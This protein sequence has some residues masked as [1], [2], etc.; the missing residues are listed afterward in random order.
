M[1]GDS[2]GARAGGATPDLT[3]EQERR[4]RMRA[5][6]M[7][8]YVQQ[9]PGANEGEAAIAWDRA[10]R[11]RYEIESG[12]RITFERPK[13]KTPTGATVVPLHPAP[14]IPFEGS[15]PDPVEA[16]PGGGGRRWPQT[17][18]DAWKRTV[19]EGRCRPGTAQWDAAVADG[20]IT[21]DVAAL[22][23]Q[24]PPART[25]GRT[26]PLKPL[27][28]DSIPHASL[29][30]LPESEPLIAGTLDQGSVALLYGA[31]QSY[32]TF[33]ALDWAASVAAGTE[34]QGRQCE[35]MNVLYVAAEGVRGIKS[36]LAAWKSSRAVSVDKE[37]EIIR[38]PVNIYDE[39]HVQQFC[40]FVKRRGF[41][42]IAIDTLARCSGGADENS[43]QDMNAIVESAYEILGSTIDG[44][45]CVL[46]V[47]HTG[48]NGGPPRGSSAL[49]NG[50]DTAYAS[51]RDGGGMI[52]VE[53][54]K[55]K[56]GPTG[57][58][59][60]L[61][62]HPVDGTGSAVLVDATSGGG[63]SADF[64]GVS[65]YDRTWRVFEASCRKNGGAS[66][67]KLIEFVRET[68]D[69]PAPSTVYR[70]LGQL[71]E[72]GVLAEVDR[73]GH[74]FIVEGPNYRPPAPRGIAPLKMAP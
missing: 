17:M 35:P 54:E 20:R 19:M 2:S 3:A 51:K 7:S 47:H 13:S 15:A 44:N 72:A 6:F 16:S 23:V 31:S 24:A 43:T 48:K 50:V 59:L 37:F 49:W 36:R 63:V 42:F 69:A 33:L 68:P 4:E 45:G 25:R 67:A 61:K 30:S 46:I 53:C 9:F 70:V 60:H 8:D 73:R 58:K 38:R 28:P 11:G 1:N 29:D 40:D 71:K 14:L 34:W 18:L 55:L 5:T 26:R 27:D 65:A 10:R 21:P 52:T 64:D 57:D 39:Q 56:D 22:A 74:P 41:Q 62:L 66:Q 32:K 12:E